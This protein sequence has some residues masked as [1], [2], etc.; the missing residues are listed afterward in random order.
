MARVE[1]ERIQGRVRAVCASVPGAI[2]Y[3]GT[4]QEALKEIEQVIPRMMERWN[5]VPGPIDLDQ[6]IF[7]G[8]NKCKCD[9]CSYCGYRRHTAIHG[10][11]LDDES[12]QRVFGH[13]FCE[14][15]ES[16]LR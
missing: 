14:K 8:G 6:C 15:P 11:I 13:L 16:I 9:V 4:K 5:C 3:G 7:G 2:A 10:G 1:F 12:K